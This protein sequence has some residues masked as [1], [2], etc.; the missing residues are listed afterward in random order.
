MS[1]SAPYDDNNIFARVLRG[2]IPSIRVF[3]DPVAL[4]FM[5]IFPQSEGHTLVIPKSTGATNLLNAD[6]K[7]LSA[8]IER[9]QLVAKAVADALN[10]DGV[11]ILQFNGAPAGQTVFHLHFHVVPVYAGAPLK[12]HAG[13]KADAGRLETL[14]AKIRSAVAGQTSA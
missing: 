9:V 6:G 4:A 12:S 7:T 8:L 11:R 3:E 1:L 10:P 5:D 13:E 14:A 2:E